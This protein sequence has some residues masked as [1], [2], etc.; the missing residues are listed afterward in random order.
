MAE[1]E[2]QGLGCVWAGGGRGEGC[3]CERAW[4]RA[5]RVRASTGQLCVGEPASVGAVLLRVLGVPSPGVESPSPSL[6]TSRRC[7]GGPQGGGHWGRPTVR[8]TGDS[9]LRASGGIY[10]QRASSKPSPRN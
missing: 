8:P 1:G 2:Q 3:G 7:W 6:V 5:D 9:G 4:P 10:N